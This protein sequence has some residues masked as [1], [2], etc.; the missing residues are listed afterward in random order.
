MP[1]QSSQDNIK[2]NHPSNQRHMEKEATLYLP[3][4]AGQDQYKL[5]R[6]F[7]YTFDFSLHVTL[8]GLF[9]LVLRTVTTGSAIQR[10]HRTKCF[11]RLSHFQSISSATSRVNLC[12]ELTKA[13]NQFSVFST[14]FVEHFCD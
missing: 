12:R 14:N 11:R 4:R 3:W 13:K 8:L 6:V 1:L 5:L 2:V 9:D 10:V 7:C